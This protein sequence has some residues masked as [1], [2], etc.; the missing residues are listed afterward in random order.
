MS[1]ITVSGCINF[2]SKTLAERTRNDV[3]FQMS[4]SEREAK[5]YDFYEIKESPLVIGAVDNNL[6]P[7]KA[8]LMD[9]HLYVCRKGFHALNI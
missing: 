4:A 7:I 9:K 8:L 3:K 5:M 1:K 6:M 2:I